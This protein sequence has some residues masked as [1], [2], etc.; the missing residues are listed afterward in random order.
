M[1]IPKATC[2]VKISWK[3]DPKH[4]PSMFKKGNWWTKMGSCSRLV[5]QFVT[6]SRS[7]LGKTW[8]NM[9]FPIDLPWKYPGIFCVSYGFLS[10][11]FRKNH[12]GKGSSSGS[13][14]SLLS[15]RQRL[16]S[17][18]GDPKGTRHWFCWENLNRKPWVFTCFHHQI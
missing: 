17:F 10:I 7:W 4:N 9:V 8:K 14:W 11:L 13:A 1:L 18:V 3:L 5:G 15:Q 6:T 2:G 12:P 16:K